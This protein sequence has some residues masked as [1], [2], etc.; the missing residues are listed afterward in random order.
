MKKYIGRCTPSGNLRHD[1]RR[2]ISLSF[3][4]HSSTS[5][6]KKKNDLRGLFVYFSDFNSF[7]ANDFRALDKTRFTTARISKLHPSGAFPYFFVSSCLRYI[8]LTTYRHETSIDTIML[9]AFAASRRFPSYS[10]ADNTESPIAVVQ[11]RSIKASN[12]FIIK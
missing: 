2:P 5:G 8:M 11:R 12:R 4:F 7:V 10:T 6:I 1:E 9:H 3:L